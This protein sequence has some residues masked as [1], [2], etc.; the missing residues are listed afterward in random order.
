MG[1]HKVAQHLS[2]CPRVLSHF[3]MPYSPCRNT[4]HGKPSKTMIMGHPTLDMR[5]IS[6][7]NERDICKISSKNIQD[8]LLKSAQ[9]PINFGNAC[10]IHFPTL[11]MK[12]PDQL[13]QTWEPAFWGV[14]DSLSWKISFQ[15]S[16]FQYSKCQSFELLLH[17]AR[18]NLDPIFILSN[19]NESAG[20]VGPRLFDISPNNNNNNISIRRIESFPSFCK[21]FVSPKSNIIGFGIHGH[22]RQVCNVFRFS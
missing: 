8:F 19:K 7:K 6:I 17:V 12:G 1:R 13:V 18:T 14:G 20:F 22:L 9:T 21:L 16:T 11:P 4:D 2:P 5:S 15:V 10:Q 3:G